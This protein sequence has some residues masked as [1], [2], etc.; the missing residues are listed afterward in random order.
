[1]V[2]VEGHLRIKAVIHIM[3]EEEVHLQGITMMTDEGLMEAEEEEDGV[4]KEILEEIT[5]E[6]SHLVAGP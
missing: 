4:M 2:E 5:Q 6:I 3:G 1:M